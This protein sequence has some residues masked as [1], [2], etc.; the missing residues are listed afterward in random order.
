MKEDNNITKREKG[1]SGQ[2][3]LFCKEMES[4][5]TGEEISRITDNFLKEKGLTWDMCVS[6][7]KDEV[8]FYEFGPSCPHTRLKPQQDV[9][10]Q[11]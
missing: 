6:L 7:C 4:H 3:F 1:E 2:S 5:T 9:Y 10:I 11:Q 8:F